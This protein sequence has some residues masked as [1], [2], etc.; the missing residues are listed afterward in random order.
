M[1]HSRSPSRQR[2]ASSTPPGE[3]I[4][5]TSRITLHS[6]IIGEAKDLDSATSS[7][8]DVH[9]SLFRTATA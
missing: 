8:R 9:K 1:H 2:P 4:I 6:E 3:G 5:W 7:F